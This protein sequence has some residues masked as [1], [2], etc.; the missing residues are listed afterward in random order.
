[1][2]LKTNLL[3]K[4][5]NKEQIDIILV[6]SIEFI[7]E[8]EKPQLGQL[9]L[10]NILKDHF[11]VE[12][13]N[14]DFLNYTGQLTFE[15]N[16]QD[17]IN[18]FACYILEKKPKAVGFYTICNSFITTIRIAEEINRINNSVKI[19]L[20]GPHASV[21]AK[22]CLEAFSFI[23]VIAIGESEYNIMDIINC[24]LYKND[25]DNVPSV[26]YRTLGGV[27]V[28]A[29]N[30]I[31]CNE[32][33]TKYTV[34]DY[35]PYIIEHNDVVLLE[36]GRGCPFACTFCS[37]SIFWGRKFRIKPINDLVTE[38]RNFNK[39]YGTTKFSLNHDLF[40]ANRKYIIEF[41]NALIEQ[42]LIIEWYCSSRIDVLDKEIITLMRKANCTSIYLGIETGSARMQKI[43]NK[44][45]DLN[46]SIE[47]IRYLVQIG[48]K[49]TVSFIYG[50]PDETEEDFIETIK[51]ID[52]IRNIGVLD[53]QLS[54][55][56]P[57]P[58]TLE[59]KKIVN[60]IYFDENDINFS[61]YKKIVF[62]EVS[63]NIIIKYPNLFIQYYSFSSKVRAEYRYFDSFFAAVLS[64]VSIFYCSIRYILS[65]YNWL[66]LY[67]NN[68]AE[69]E[70]HV[71]DHLHKIDSYKEDSRYFIE[72]SCE[73][74]KNKLI[75][76]I[77]TNDDSIYLRAAYN[78]E[79]LFLEYIKN[80]EKREIIYKINFDYV[81]MRKTMNV[82]PKKV[83][84]VFKRKF[85]M[86]IIEQ[87]GIKMVSD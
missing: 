7:Y 80:F 52:I 53:I 37:T 86:P 58:E 70:K 19:F 68:L 13:I 26:A 47:K 32:E 15:D 9:I 81:K 63:K 30:R 49:L 24:L 21:V 74:I 40:T 29:S 71:L 3:Y 69:I 59:T 64:A 62:D 65:H 84:I 51:M 27:K 36:G 87:Y 75:E 55:F 31:V 33:L 11:S 45:L 43:I 17:N 56:I 5:N 67:K 35:Y 16:L 78:V 85:N 54:R 23:D 8:K 60:K 79:K 83:K 28:N 57:L 6:N 48:I 14:F 82:I 44:N 39:L 61:I 34:Y 42:E 38:M 77:L 1:M 76:K 2:D 66:E 72:N 46:N 4:Y 22:E 50:Y 73:F 20:G 12:C 41:C 25:F 18:N 10:K